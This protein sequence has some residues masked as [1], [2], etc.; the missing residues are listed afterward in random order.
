MLPI[1]QLFQNFAPE[2]PEATRPLAFVGNHKEGR[3]EIG[4]YPVRSQERVCD[5][6]ERPCLGSP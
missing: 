1:Y 4:E 6:T 5:P 3:G 2:G